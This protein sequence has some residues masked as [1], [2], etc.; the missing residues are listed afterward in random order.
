MRTYRLQV[1]LLQAAVSLALIV[2][3]AGF[4]GVFDEGAKPNPTTVGTPESAGDSTPV[5]SNPKIVA[6]GDSFTYG[7][8]GGP[9]QAWP[10]RLEELLQAPVV[11]KGQVK[12]TAQ[13]LFE[14]FDQDVLTE[15]PGR[16]IIFVGT[17]D[18]LQGVKAETYQNNVK[19]MVD[20]AKSNHIIPV[21]ALPLPYPGSKQEVQKSITDM[22]EWMLNL[23]QTEQILVLDFAS[24]LFDHEGKGIK[25]LF[26][27]DNYPNNK[28]YEEM[29]AYAARVL[30]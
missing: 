21:L 12:Q 2:L 6:L 7:Y 16:V 10:R 28:G 30:K 4:S 13:N 20:K 11:N 19:G 27:D 5:V 29:A 8:P 15:K 22:R 25:E 17:G 18:A 3:I 14:R 24:V 1:R 26:A 23:A 9:E